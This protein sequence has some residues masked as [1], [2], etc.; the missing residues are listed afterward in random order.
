MDFQPYQ[1]L[2]GDGSVSDTHTSFGSFRMNLKGFS[3]EF[4]VR[5]QE[6]GVRIPRWQVHFKDR[7]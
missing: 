7:E 2:R 6:S 1:S 4:G 3:G 5:S